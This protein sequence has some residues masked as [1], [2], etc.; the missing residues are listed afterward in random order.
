ME[1]HIIIIPS[2][3]I[4]VS[5]YESTTTTWL[6]TFNWY[7][8]GL[9][10]AIAAIEIYIMIGILTFY[11]IF[12]IVYTLLWLIIPTFNLIFLAGDDD[13][14][15]TLMQTHNDIFYFFCFIQ[16]VQVYLNWNLQISGIATML[17]VPVTGG[18][19]AAGVI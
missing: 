15:M 11:P 4:K 1:Q 19:I 8:L 14:R 16:V 13:N 5:W 7:F 2:S 6:K 18:S 3:S 9:T 12:V 10:L 17:N